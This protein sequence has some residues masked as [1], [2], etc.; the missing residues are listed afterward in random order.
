MAAI[1]SVDDVIA[2]VARSGAW[3]Q[4]LPGETG[5]HY[6]YGQ[7]GDTSRPAPNV[8]GLKLQGRMELVSGPGS[9]PS[10]GTV[11]ATGRKPRNDSRGYRKRYEVEVLS[12]ERAMRRCIMCGDQ[13]DSY[14][15]SHR[16]CNEC[17]SKLNCNHDSTYYEPRKAKGV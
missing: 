2:E 8:I 17:Q 16:R 4:L 14:T 12:T 11:V 13:F 6:Y 10:Y 3:Y 1:E 9:T 15:R 7:P 5:R